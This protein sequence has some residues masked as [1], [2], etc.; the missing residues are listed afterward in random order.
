MSLVVK[1]QK[2]L[3]LIIPVYNEENY[4]L[5]CLESIAQ[6]TIMPLEVIVVDNNSTDSTPDIAKSF[7]FV[8]LVREKRQHQ[9]YAQHTGFSLAKG[10]IL[11]RIDADTVLPPTWVER[12][13]AEFEKNPKMLGFCGSGWAY[14][15]ALQRFGKFIYGLYFGVAN[16]FAGVQLIWGSNSVFKASAWKDIKNEVALRDDIWEDYDLAFCLG[17]HG[18]I[19]KMDNDV[20]VSY[21][22]IHRSP[23]KQLRYQTRSIRTFLLHRNHPTAILFGTLWFSMIVLGPIVMFDYYVLRPLKD[24][25]PFKLLLEAAFPDI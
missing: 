16:T 10:D 20:S 22:A 14:D 5:G 1:K 21:R 12:S 9:S 18:R 13:L 15:I 6:Q 17:K 7:N 19:G 4:L 23:L 3:S 8:R 11:G 24:T 2:T 25:R